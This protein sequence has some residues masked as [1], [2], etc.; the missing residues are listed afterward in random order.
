MPSLAYQGFHSE[1]VSLFISIQ[2]QKL[3]DY[4]RRVALLLNKMI[5]GKPLQEQG[6]VQTECQIAFQP[7]PQVSSKRTLC[8]NYF[9]KKTVKI[10]K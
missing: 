4:W 5:L 10:L 3:D 7:T 1:T 6:D 8:G 2:A 9:R